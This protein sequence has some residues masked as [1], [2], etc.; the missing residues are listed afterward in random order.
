MA[1]I[2]VKEIFDKVVAYPAAPQNLEQAKKRDGYG[3][4][5][6]FVGA[7]LGAIFLGG[8]GAVLGAPVGLKVGHV[9]AKGFDINI[10]S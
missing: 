5:C 8:A 10:P 1:D 7:A 9:L 4:V 6:A 2:N 3:L